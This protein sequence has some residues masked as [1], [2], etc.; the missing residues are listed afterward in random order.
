MA[1]YLSPLIEGAPSLWHEGAM[2]GVDMAM[3]ASLSTRASALVALMTLRSS[4]R[5]DSD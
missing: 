2:D 1:I 5:A 3:P 4:I